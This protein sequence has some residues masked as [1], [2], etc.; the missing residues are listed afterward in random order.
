[1]LTAD[2]ARELCWGYSKN[3]KLDALDKIEKRIKE[4][5]NNG[6]YDVKLLINDYI[7]NVCKYN[8]KFFDKSF[9]G[10]DEY[11]FTILKFVIDT[12]RSNGFK[13]SLCGDCLRVCWD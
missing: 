3:D 1:M 8:N 4:I 10:Y 5:S 7:P 11:G 9:S 6:F 12:L 13:T 2:M